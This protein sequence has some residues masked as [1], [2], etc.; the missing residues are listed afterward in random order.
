MTTPQTTREHIVQAADSL[1]YRHGF[2]HT[3]FADIAAAVGISRGN[4]YHHF[5]SKDDILEAVL[6]ERVAATAKKLEDWE[7]ANERPAE[8]I[9][10]F[11]D[12]LF[13]GR[14]KLKRY[15]CPAGTLCAELAKLGHASQP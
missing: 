7:R 8:R 12:M 5:Q 9:R 1:F 14:T 15:G 10:A 3:S 4:F 11:I 6:A 2:E 13:A